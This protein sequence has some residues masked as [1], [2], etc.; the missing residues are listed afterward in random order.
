MAKK[1]TS[2]QKAIREGLAEQ[3][4]LQSIGVIGLT[5]STPKLE[6]GS[7]PMPSG[8]RPDDLE[9]LD[10][11][12]R[13]AVLTAQNAPPPFAPHRDDDIIVDA[14]SAKTVTAALKRY[15]A[16]QSKMRAARRE[17]EALKPLVRDAAFEY[18][19]RRYVVSAEHRREWT[20]ATLLY[21]NYQKHAGECAANIGDA[22]I[23][24]AELASET[25]F[26]I[27]L[28][29]AGLVS[30]RRSR[31]DGNYYPLRLKQGA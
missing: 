1:P 16:A 20:Q 29:E 9:G 14:P 8:P 2:L 4:R 10:G 24:K 7:L 17:I 28:R 6:P 5:R 12:D 22:A 26:G 18:W 27:L 3:A 31:P 21:E 13:K 15:K 11:G 30:E 19:L 25:R 23:L